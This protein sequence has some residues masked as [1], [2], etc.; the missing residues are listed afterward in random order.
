M[1]L[2]IIFALL[3]LSF[4]IFF[5]EK[6]HLEEF[7]IVFCS[8]LSTGALLSV[9]DKD[10]FRYVLI[11]FFVFILFTF[12]LGFLQLPVHPYLYK[13]LRRFKMMLYLY[14]GYCFATLF[15]ALTLFFPNFNF[16]IL[17]LFMSLVFGACFIFIWKMYF[18]VPIQSF[19]LWALLASFILWEITFVMHLLPFGYLV[20]GALIVW[21]AYML[22]L[23]LR[24]HLSK[25]G[26]EIKRQLPF[27]IINTLLFILVLTFFVRWV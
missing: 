26:L 7:L 11:A 1:L 23:V 5:F 3:L 22:Q 24:F 25:R 9:L 12:Y 10:I 18:T 8:F 13:P 17:S 14:F 27:L 2:L 15:F 20:M 6:F 16:G 21:F 19:I 4:H